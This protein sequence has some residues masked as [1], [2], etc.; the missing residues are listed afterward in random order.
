MSVGTRTYRIADAETRKRFDAGDVVWLN[1]RYPPASNVLRLAVRHAIY[2]YRKSGRMLDAAL[3]YARF[4]V[5]VFPVTPD[6]KKPIP[7]RDYDPD[8]KYPDGIPGTGGI[9]KATTDPIR[10]RKWW[11]DHPKALI[12][13]PTG[14]LSSVWVLDIDTAEEH[15]DGTIGWA[16]L[17]AQH[18]PIITRGHRSATGGPHLIFAW[19]PER[20]LGCGKGMLPEGIQ[21]KG[22]GGYIVVPPPM[23]RGRNYTVHADINPIAAPTWLIELI[24]QGRPP[25]KQQSN[26]RSGQRLVQFDGKPEIDQQELAEIVSFVP[27]DDL[28]WDEWSSHAM[29]MFVASGGREWGFEI[30]DAWSQTS[31]KYEEG[32]T[33]ERW[34]GIAGSPPN[35]TGVNKLRKIA[36]AHGWRPGLFA[37]TP[38]YADADDY[39]TDAK[40]DAIRKVARDFFDRLIKPQL[41]YDNIIRLPYRP[42][43]PVLIIPNLAHVVDSEPPPLVR[44]MKSVTGGGKTTL[45]I[46][47]LAKWLRQHGRAYTPIIYGVPMHALSEEVKQQFTKLGIDAWIFRGYMAPDPDD[48]LNIEKLKLNPNTR[49][50]LAPMCRMSDRVLTAMQARLKISSACCK[51]GKDKCPHYEGANICPY[52]QQYPEEGDW[53]DVWIVASDMVFFQH[54]IFAKAKAV[55]IDET[56][57]QKGLRGIASEEE[58]NACTVPLAI[59]QHGYR[60]DLGE[61]LQLQESDG[62][63]EACHLVGIDL[64]VCKDGIK[65][66]WKE[67]A[68]RERELAMYPGM[69][70]RLFRKLREEKQQVIEALRRARLLITIWQEVRRL[71]QRP[72]IAVSGRLRLEQVNGLRCV[73]WRGIEALQRPYDKLPTLLADALLPPRQILQIFHPSVKI[74]ADINA[75][76]SPHV[77][78]RQILDAP[79]TSIK[80]DGERNL[81]AV[82]HYILQEYLLSGRKDTLV[83]CQKKVHEWLQKRGLPENIAV[84]HYYDISGLD[85]YKAVALGILIGRPAPGPG[86]IEEIA[87]ALSGEWQPPMPPR[88]NGFAWYQKVRRG[89]RLVSGGGIRTSGDLHLAPMSEPVRWGSCEGELINAHGRFRAI[90]RTAEYPCTIRWLFD[91]C[92]P[93][94]VDEVVR[95]QQPSPLAERAAF[96]GLLSSDPVALMELFPDK[97]K[98][99]SAARWA[100]KDGVLVPPGF[101]LIEYRFVDRWRH[102]GR[103]RVVY[104]DPS[105]ITDPAAD[106][107]RRLGR[108][109]WV[110][111]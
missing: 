5:P 2:A 85:A 82:W 9:Y 44:A 73:S 15:V 20:P 99:R 14:R 4:G 36:R 95:W 67:V 25:P 51:Q 1:Q 110:K 47:E 105:V 38:S 12:G 106:L 3:A 107:E 48:P 89:V 64:Q 68:R 76:S 90:N 56:F 81:L 69:S 62:W 55:I 60:R 79:T 94:A 83:I 10:I 27:N 26:T 21:V 71:L 28:G 43:R 70:K 109:V 19:D 100:I 87:G 42:R 74:V 65:Q 84:E 24:S 86:Q 57:W 63:L 49:E 96:D 80:L 41:D 88:E 77:H 58:D 31:G 37:E 34:R 50:E 29:A 75:K 23:R 54:E 61:L 91:T 104:Y 101:R 66:E 33:R 52:R 16:E 22:Q 13:L 17:A 45:I 98:T 59:L 78:V 111:K 30:F 97:F 53:P 32:Y 6:R 103:A 8:G 93:I 40:R 11:R 18:E 108:R 102:K 35:R 39:M 72:E 92:L 7:K 46:E